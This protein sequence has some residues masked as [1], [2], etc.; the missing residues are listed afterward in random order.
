MQSDIGIATRAQSYIHCY[1]VYRYWLIQ[2]GDDYQQSLV[3]YDCSCVRDSVSKLSDYSNHKYCDALDACHLSWRILFYAAWQHCISPYFTGFRLVF[4]SR[5]DQIVS[6]N[7]QSL[8][9]IDL[10]EANACFA[11][12]PPGPVEIVLKRRAE[13]RLAV[14]TSKAKK[15]V[16]VLVFISK[17]CHPIVHCTH[18]DVH[19]H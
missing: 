8:E 6:V 13:N 18:N 10:G 2:H 19:H 15:T 12:L 11:Q 16:G 17:E 14:D 4:Y 9:D 7:G 3:S 5:G 1:V